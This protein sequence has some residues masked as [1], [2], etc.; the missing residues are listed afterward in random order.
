MNRI[1]FI[2]NIHDIFKECGVCHLGERER[3]RERERE[4]EREIRI[5]HDTLMTK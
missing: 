5:R 4:R 1:K 3:D 2:M